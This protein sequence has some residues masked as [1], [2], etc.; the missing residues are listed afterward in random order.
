MHCHTP[1]ASTIQYGL[2]DAPM[3]L[4]MSCHD[5]PVGVSKDEVMAA[6]TDEITD[7]KF[8]HGP[9]AQKDCKGCHVSHGTLITMTFVSAAIRKTW[10]LRSGRPS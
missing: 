7:K 4:C 9:V 5:K 1:H 6:L 8:L 2:K 10:C 3:A